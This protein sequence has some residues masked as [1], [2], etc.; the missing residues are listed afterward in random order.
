MLTRINRPYK[1]SI[2]I[3]MKWYLLNKLQSLH[4]SCIK[5]TMMDDLIINI[6]HNFPKPKAIIWQCPISVIRQI[7]FIVCLKTF[8]KPKQIHFC[9][10]LNWPLVGPCWCNRKKVSIHFKR[11]HLSLSSI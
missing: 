11:P 9:F 10:L 8:L 1:Q 2:D 7:F 4:L 3:G 6:L 5:V